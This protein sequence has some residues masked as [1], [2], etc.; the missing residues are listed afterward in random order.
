MNALIRW[1]VIALFP[2]LLTACLPLVSIPLFSNGGGEEKSIEMNLT[3]SAA[4]DVNPDVEGEP[5]PIEIRVYQLTSSAEFE[6]ADFYSLYDDKALETSLVQS[7]TIILEPGH[8]DE[9]TIKLDRASQFVA[10][11]AAFQDIDNAK[12]HDL[13]LIK[14]S[15]GFIKKLLKSSKVLSLSLVA[16]K[17]EITLSDKADE[18]TGWRL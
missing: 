10:V 18:S 4:E 9:I 16:E 14:D 13:M 2:W 3:V 12:W 7:E 17:N 5:S 1:A 8:N 6:K 11:I 15:R